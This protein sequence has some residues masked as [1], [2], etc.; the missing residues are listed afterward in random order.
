MFRSNGLDNVLLHF[1]FPFSLIEPLIVNLPS[2][3]AFDKAILYLHSFFILGLEILLRLFLKEEVLGNLHG[4]KMA[5]S[6]LPISHLIF[7]DDVMI[8]S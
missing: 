2:L 5:R 6:C 1:I 3:G 7:A 4:I 8:F